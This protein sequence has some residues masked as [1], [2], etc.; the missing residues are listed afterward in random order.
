MKYILSLLFIILVSTSYSQSY[1]VEEK[2]VIK[3]IEVLFEAMKA[4]DSTLAKSAFHSE[5]SMY[6]TI[7]KDD[8]T[9]LHK[10]DLQQF[11]TAIGSPKAQ[12]WEEKVWDFEVQIDQS[13]AQV[14][15]KYAFYVDGQFSHCG[16]DA[17]QLVKMGES[18]KIFNVADTRQREGCE[19]PN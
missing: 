4:N 8:Q 2:G 13:L 7:V 14:W 6:T 11:L 12:T 15:C 19:Q 9:I 18:W 10:G 1:S 3:P 16:I 17:F 5:V